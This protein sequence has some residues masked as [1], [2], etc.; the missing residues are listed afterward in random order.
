MDVHGITELFTEVSAG[1]FNALWWCKSSSL[2]ICFCR[3][4]PNT[5]QLPHSALL[6]AHSKLNLANR[7][8][9]LPTCEGKQN[10]HSVDSL[11]LIYSDPYRSEP[12]H[13]FK[14]NSIR[15]PIWIW[16]NKWPSIWEYFPPCCIMTI[17]R[18]LW[19]DPLERGWFVGR[20]HLPGY[21]KTWRARPCNVNVYFPWA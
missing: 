6:P 3:N 14:P 11:F 18:F 7:L 20:R 8:S 12:L 1:A 21:W 9:C 5:R 19:H 10:D 17:N 13:P 4:R 2:G 15:I 16:E